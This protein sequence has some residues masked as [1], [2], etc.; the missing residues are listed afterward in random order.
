M[1]KGPLLA[2]TV[3]DGVEYD[4][5]HGDYARP[6]TVWRGRWCIAWFLA[7]YMTLAHPTP[8][9]D[10]GYLDEVAARDPW[11]PWELRA[12]AVAAYRSAYREV[13]A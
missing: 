12:R 6:L 8:K 2:T 11:P 1:D 5:R 7:S 10:T 13:V 4:I 9:W 3:V